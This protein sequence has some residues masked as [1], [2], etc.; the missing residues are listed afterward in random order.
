MTKNK[1]YYCNIRVTTNYH[2]E[3]LS[4]RDIVDLNEKITNIVEDWSVKM[5]EKG[6]AM[7][8]GWDWSEHLGLET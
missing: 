6:I 5:V 3:N 1:T 4:K 8:I 2:A 7:D